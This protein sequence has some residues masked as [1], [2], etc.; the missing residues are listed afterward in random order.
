MTIRISGEVRLLEKKKCLNSKISLLISKL[1]KLFG[2]AQQFIICT[3]YSEF[4]VLK[5]NTDKTVT[6]DWH[7]KSNNLNF[8]ITIKEKLY[9]KITDERFIVYSLLCRSKQFQS[10]MN[11][12][13]HRKNIEF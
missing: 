13:E 2:N 9:L 12:V 5:K 1:V 10:H 3:I 6:L 4:T 11:S 7:K 8:V